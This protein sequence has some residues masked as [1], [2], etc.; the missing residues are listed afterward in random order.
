MHFRHR[1]ANC[2]TIRILPNLGSHFDHSDA[3]SATIRKQYSFQSTHSRHH[4]YI[5]IKYHFN[6]HWQNLVTNMSNVATTLRVATFRNKWTSPASCRPQLSRQMYR[7]RSDTRYLSPLLF[8]PSGSSVSSFRY[9]RHSTTSVPNDCI[10]D[11]DDE[12]T[13]PVSERLDALVKKG[14]IHKDDHQLMAAR[15]LDRLYYDLMEQN[16]PPLI[17]SSSSSSSSSPK[18]T[19]SSFF[20]SLFGGATNKSPAVGNSNLASSDLHSNLTGSI[21]GCYMYGG[22]GCGKTFLMDLLYHSI[23]DASHSPWSNDRQMVHYHKFMLNVHEF[24]HTSRREHRERGITD[25]NLIEPVVSHIL[26][27]GRLLCLDEFQVTDVAD[28]MILKEVFTGIWKQG[29]VLVTTSNRPPCDLYL[30]GLQRDRFV[31]FID[32]LERRCHVVNLMKAERDYRMM[33]AKEDAK[34]HELEDSTTTTTDTTSN[35]IV[36]KKVHFTKDERKDL[37]R[38]FAQMTKDRP[39]NPTTLETQG[40]KVKIPMAC[41]SKSVAKFSF[42]DVCQKA[43]GAADYLVIGQQ[44][45]TVFLHGIPPL[46]VNELNWFRRFITFVDSMYELKVTLILHTNA[47]SIDEIFTV[48]GDKKS[49]N[50][51]EVFAFDRTR[52]RLQEMS[53]A[54]YLTSTWQGSTLD[55]SSNRQVV[56]ARIDMEPS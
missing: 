33:M 54:K 12:L 16:P 34:R 18:N 40:R 15:E 19:S 13:G 49:Y 5:I 48:E 55:G 24:M 42:E 31:P 3:L 53:T 2:R 10:S 21:A 17:L 6:L 25:V 14:T 51:D 56:T 38:L 8:P 11:F 23:G 20:G 26:E 4:D 52:S 44:F 47:A 32:M 46:T 1:H 9:Q 37:Q 45:S 29:G 28:A 22:V 43:L 41:Q 39:C 7:F 36:P 30:H 27:R 50:Q 35:R